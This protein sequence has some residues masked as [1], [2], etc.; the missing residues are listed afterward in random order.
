MLPRRCWGRNAADYAITGTGTD[1]RAT[2]DDCLGWTSHT[3]PYADHGFPHESRGSWT[4]TGDF[5]E[6]CGSFFDR[7][8]CFGSVPVTFWD[9]FEQGGPGRWWVARPQPE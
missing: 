1:G 8:Y 5:T 2:G 9:S 7:L 3:S 4:R 6:G